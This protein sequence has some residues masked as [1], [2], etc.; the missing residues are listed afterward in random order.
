MTG[1]GSTFSVSQKAITLTEDALGDEQM[2]GWL[3]FKTGASWKKY[4]RGAPR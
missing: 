3:N 1:S 4:W 2:K